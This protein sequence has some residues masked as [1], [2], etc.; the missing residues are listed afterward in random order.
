MIEISHVDKWYNANFQALK[1]CSTHV[2]KGEVIVTGP[3][4]SA[5]GVAS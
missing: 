1:D 3:F 5:I 4:S 2:D